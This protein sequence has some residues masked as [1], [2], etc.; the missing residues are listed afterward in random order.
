MARVLLIHDGAA[1]ETARNLR[2]VL[3]GRSHQVSRASDEL[4]ATGG[5]D[6]DAVIID[7]GNAGLHITSELRRR[8]PLLGIVLLVAPGD[9][10]QSRV[11]GLTCGADFCEAKPVGFDLLSAYVDAIARRGSEGEWRLDTTARTLRAPR[12]A[13]VEINDKEVALL[14]LLAGSA[15]HAADRS[16]I[17]RAFGADW[18]AFDERVLEKTVSRLRRK[19]RE[20][21]MTDLPLK[22]VHGVG[23]CF[24]ERLQVC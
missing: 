11:D 2:L 20:G 8:E 23:Y 3:E 15:R 4:L 16:S 13:E 17:A 1:R 14:K 21:A 9:G 6:A 12:C 22:T 24:T 7:A 5:I 10:T 19:W 18:M